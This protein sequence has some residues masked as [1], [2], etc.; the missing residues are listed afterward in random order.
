MINI[1]KKIFMLLFVALVTGIGFSV[2]IGPAFAICSL[3]GHWGRTFSNLLSGMLGGYII[4]MVIGSAW[5]LI[6]EFKK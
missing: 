6:K 5:F 1:L 4:G 3:L 2:L